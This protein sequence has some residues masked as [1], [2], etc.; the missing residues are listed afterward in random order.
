MVLGLYQRNGKVLAFPITSR[1]KRELIP[2]MT[3][4]TKAGSLYYADDW[5]AYT[6]L[7]I[8]GGHVIRKKEK[9][10][11]K[12]RDHLNGIEGF[13][14][15]ARHWLYHYRGAPRKYFHLYLKEIGW[16]FSHRSENL[17]T[18]LHKLMAHRI[19]KEQKLV[20]L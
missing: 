6:F 2:L 3:E 20:Q 8:R 7:D 1:G 12:G 11:P 19:V 18:L 17:V 9:G 13:W 14:S 10:K 4:H 15:C 16:R 5:H